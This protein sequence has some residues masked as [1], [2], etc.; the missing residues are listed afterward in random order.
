M[1]ATEAIHRADRLADH[2]GV[3]VCII[4]DGGIKI[5]PQRQVCRVGKAHLVLETCRPAMGRKNDH[6]G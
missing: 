4:D 3:P 6:T 1:T 5:L 2:L